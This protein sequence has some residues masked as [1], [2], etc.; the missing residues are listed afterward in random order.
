M[1]RHRASHKGVGIARATRKQKETVLQS[2]LR[3]AVVAPNVLWRLIDAVADGLAL[4]DDEGMLVLVNRPVNGMFGY[5]PGELIGRP[6]ETVIPVGLQAS[7]R[8]HRAAYARAPTVRPMAAGPRLVGLRKDGATFPG[9]IS[10]S[11]VPAATGQ[12]TL[13][14]IRDVT[15]A[16]Q[17]G[18]LIDFAQAAVV[19]MA[20][21]RSCCSQEN[22]AQAR[23]CGRH[24][25]KWR[26]KP[27]PR[28]PVTGRTA[29]LV[30]RACTA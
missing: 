21:A 23:T 1:V 30:G 8:S 15:A 27:S 2:G 17:R 5:G 3:A 7:H 6:V 16:R 10:L 29:G 14:V 19:V 11:P 4:T 12:F 26:R 9:K 24:L 18:A 22:E 13:A 25:G 28:R 20:S